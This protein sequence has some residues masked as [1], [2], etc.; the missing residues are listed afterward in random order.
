MT[1][2]FDVRS[3]AEFAKE[4]KEYHKK[5]AEIAVRLAISV[6][7]KTGEWPDIKPN[8]IDSSGSLIESDQMVTADPDYIIGDRTV[9]ITHSKYVL[10][11]TFHEKQNKIKKMQVEQTDMVFVNGLSEK[12]PTFLWLNAEEW[13][14]FIQRSLT[15]YGIVPMLGGGKVGF[16]NKNAY[17]FDI[18]W[19]KDLFKPLP[20]LIS[21]VPDAYKE[22]LN[23]AR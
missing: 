5:E 9:E 4:I 14:P 2:R 10:G 8:G 12:Q 23:N 6:H 18:Y 11:R 16:L 17:R 21:S 15:K 22:I 1:H 3:K 20:V 7:A 13:E 19:F